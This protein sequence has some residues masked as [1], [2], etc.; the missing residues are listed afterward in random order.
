MSK[1]KKMV[2]IYVMGRQYLVPAGLTIMKAMEYAG[3]RFIRG[4]GCRGGFCGACATVYRKEGDYKLYTD[5]AC[6]KTV[7]DGMYLVQ[8]PFVPANKA[9]YNLEEIKPSPNVILKYY[10]EVARCLSCNTCTR[11]CPQGIEVMQAVQAALRGDVEQVAELSF[12]C[13]QC[14]L[15]AIRCPAEIPQYHVFQLARRIYGKYIQ[16]PAKHVRDRIKEIEEGKYEEEYKKLL[17]A[18]VEELKKI[19]ES[20]GRIEE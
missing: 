5:L 3:Y 19:Y 1:E 11:A 18:S 20:R 10:P 7:E 14:G 8:L 9:V 16:K 2:R 12:D 17:E 13:I 4:A 6:Q 15:C